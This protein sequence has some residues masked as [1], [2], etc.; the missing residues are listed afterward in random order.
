MF[1][2]QSSLTLNRRYHMNT[3]LAQ[4]ESMRDRVWSTLDEFGDTPDGCAMLA[5]ILAE[6]ASLRAA[7]D[8]PVN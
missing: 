8:G 1:D 2:F 3:R 7:L 5:E 4:L 6:I